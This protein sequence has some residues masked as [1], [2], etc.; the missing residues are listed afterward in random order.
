MLLGL[1]AYWSILFGICF[2][3]MRR[4]SLDVTSVV[5]GGVG[6]AGVAVIFLVVVTVAIS[7]YLFYLT[8]RIVCELSNYYL[9]VQIG[10]HAPTKIKKK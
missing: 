10:P 3:L 2:Q 7:L 6:H 4:S 1:I 9:C 5:I 8:T